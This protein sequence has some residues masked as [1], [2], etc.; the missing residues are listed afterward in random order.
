MPILWIFM[1]TLA[2]FIIMVISAII[3]YNAANLPLQNKHKN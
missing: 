3:I 2:V 1:N